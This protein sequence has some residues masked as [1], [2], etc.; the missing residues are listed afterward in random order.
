MDADGQWLIPVGTLSSFLK[1]AMVPNCPQLRAHPYATVAHTSVPPAEATKFGLCCG[2]AIVLAR[3]CNHV[4]VHLQKGEV[5][6]HPRMRGEA[7]PCGFYGCTT[8]KCTTSIV[9]K[10]I[11][12][13]CPLKHTMA[14]RKQENMPRECPIPGCTATR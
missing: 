9:H 3:M 2:V 4:V 13:T 1:T 12:S 5:V 10:K 7:K 11:S 6:I 14:M 8:G